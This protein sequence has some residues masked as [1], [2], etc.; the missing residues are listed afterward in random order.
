MKFYLHLKIKLF[1]QRGTIHLIM[2]YIKSNITQRT[3]CATSNCQ[4]LRLIEYPDFE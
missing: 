1:R 3:K 4:N 2:N